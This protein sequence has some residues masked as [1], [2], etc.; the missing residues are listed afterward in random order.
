V[1]SGSTFQ[2]MVDQRERD[3]EI[4]PKGRNRDPAGQPF[5]SVDM[6]I[7]VH[8]R[9]GFAVWVLGAGFVP[10]RPVLAQG[11]S[12][13]TEQS[14][15]KALRDVRPDDWWASGLHFVDLDGDDR[16]DVFVSGHDSYGALAA[17]G[18]GAGVFKQAAG[19]YPSSEIHI[20]YD[21]DEDGRIDLSMTYEDGGGRWWTNA[22]TQ[23]ALSFVGT[24]IQRTGNTSRIQVMLDVNQDG[25]VDWVRAS[26][27]ENGV[28]VDYGDGHGDFKQ[29]SSKLPGLGNTNPIPV[30]IDA[31]GDKDWLTSYGDYRY[32]PGKTNL[33]REDGQ[34]ELRDITVESG[35]YV[36]MLATQGVGDLDNDGDSD[37]IAIENE[38]FPPSIFLNNGKGHFTRLANAVSGVP[39]APVYP[40]WGLGV[41]TDLDN[42]GIA[43]L[44][45]DG[46]IYLHVL[47]GTGGGKFE[48]MNTRWGIKNHAEASVDSGFA[49]ADID[50]DGDLDV[51]SWQ[52]TDPKHL[53]ALYRNDLAKKHWI[54][55]RPVG[56]AGNRGAAGAKIR[57]Y[58]A[59]TDQLLWYE[60]VGIYCRQAQPS[61]G[62][63]W[64]LSERHFG[65][66]DRTKVDL[67]VEFY[68]SHKLVRHNG[69]DA[70]TTV[71]ITEDGV[72]SVV[73]YPAARDGGTNTAALD[74]GSD[75]ATPTG[76]AATSQE[77]ASDDNAA[78]TADND[79][80]P[81]GGGDTDAGSSGDDTRADLHGSACDM[82]RPSGPERF[83]FWFSLAPLLALRCGMRRRR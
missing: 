81:A 69:A 31:D 61:Y 64:P 27:T 30:D 48:Y 34:L 44:L 53:F 70:D 68:P 49:F 67:T 54:R 80:E 36:D 40:T 33:Y 11:F 32:E 50:Q 24:K 79:S 14:G 55:V 16:L 12:D 76:D 1:I 29:A 65:L 9:R 42:D 52:Q 74:A 47:R 6:T 38:K 46:R 37:F 4:V 77:D 39:G 19:N 62:Y 5:P 15:L 78:A 57:I 10:W 72:G 22:S 75:G 8:L 20:P 63:H 58:A 2:V 18:D 35:L 66:A 45:F 41:V 25:K 60:E 7:S 71:R 43:D 83:L 56:L 82:S 51:L 26:E 21:V 59:G 73:S 13:I 3:H 17:L 23:G 28:I